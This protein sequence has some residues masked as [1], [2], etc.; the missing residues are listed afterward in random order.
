MD[1]KERMK[2]GIH[3]RNEAKE[4]R[5]QITEDGFLPKFFLNMGTNLMKSEN[6]WGRVTLF[7]NFLPPL[8]M[9]SSYLGRN[10]TVTCCSFFT[11]PPE[12]SSE[13]PLWWLYTILYATIS[14][15]L[16]PEYKLVN[17]C[18]SVLYFMWIPEYLITIHEVSECV[19][20]RMYLIYY[21]F[22][23]VAEFSISRISIGF[24]IL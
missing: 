15:F 11:L 19:F 17:L 13:N 23:S 1:W 5:I 6:S 12:F 18:C 14:K 7:L 3:W 9:T 21:I 16:I 4:E 24:N 2:I 20:S 10:M 8:F 22:I